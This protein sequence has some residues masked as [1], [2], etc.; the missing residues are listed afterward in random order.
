VDA[1]PSL[2]Q[3]HRFPVEIINHCVRLSHQFPLSWRDIEKMMAPR[4]VIISYETIHPWC[5]KFG[6]SYTNGLRRRRARP[7]THGISTKR[8]HQDCGQNPLPMAGVDRAG[9]VLD[10]P[11]T[12]RRDAKAATRSLPAPRTSRPTSVRLRPPPEQSPDGPEPGDQ[13]PRQSNAR[14]G[15]QLVQ[16]YPGAGADLT[17][18]HPAIDPDQRAR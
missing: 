3:G 15:K 9:N 11:V 10:I 12:S 16:Q 14:T 2:Y 6:Q 5:R 7:G 17:F 18:S 8:P 1:T 4:G 13:P